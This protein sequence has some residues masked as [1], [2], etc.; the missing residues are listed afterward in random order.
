MGCMRFFF[1]GSTNDK[2]STEGRSSVLRLTFVTGTGVMRFI[3]FA[4]RPS[5]TVVVPTSVG[6]RTGA[7]GANGDLTDADVVTSG[8]SLLV[9]V[10]LMGTFT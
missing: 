5:R 8:A 6:G 4:G 1:L 7:A 3:F 2:S 9:G 10:P